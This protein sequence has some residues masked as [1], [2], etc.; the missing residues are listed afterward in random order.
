VSAA[1]VVE[2]ADA[3]APCRALVT[4]ATGFLGGALVRRLTRAGVPVRALVRSDAQAARLARA[5]VD[6]VVGDVTDEDAVAAAT[7]GVAVV[8]HLAGKLYEPWESPDDYRRIH[9]DGTKRLLEAARHEPRLRRFVHCSTT[10]VLGSTGTSRADERA[11]LRPSNV[12]EET[13]A[14]AELE[15]LA[16]CEQGF[17]A[18][19]ARPGLVYGPGDLHLV[20]F[21][22]AVLKRQFRPIGS[23]PVWLHP[24]FID[25]LTQAFL[26]CAV[27]PHAVGEC[28]HLAGREPVSLEELAATIARA[29]G[30]TPAAGRIPMPAARAL[31]AVG[32]ALP[33]TLRRSA[34]LTRS[35]LD[36]LTH[37]RVYC[38]S[39]AERLL[40]FVA[41]TPLTD[42]VARSVSWYRE[43]GYLPA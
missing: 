27:S 24:I 31:A 18:V 32:D 26:Q 40:P 4:G 35:R 41:P 15:V 21:F 38:V 33:P 37:S 13:K 28:F 36:F 6:T 43:F 1:E 25:D 42:G 11:P 23:A 34:P 39:K 10:G 14:E 17:P 12:Y 22:R 9:V 20:G 2:V 5:G 8:F 29:A 3:P 7:D 30:I 16:A 19:V